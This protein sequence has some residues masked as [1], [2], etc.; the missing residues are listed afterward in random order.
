MSYSLNDN[1]YKKIL[2]YYQ[3]DIPK[4]SRILKK[5]AED[6]IGLK[7]CSCIKKVGVV[8]EPKSIG[9]CTKAVINRKGMIRGKFTCKKQRKIVLKK[10]NKGTL[11]ISTKNANKT[12]KYRLK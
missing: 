1:D 3:L 5:K 12:R 4:S 10:V 6:I 7:L 11:S 9:V 8:N 2:K